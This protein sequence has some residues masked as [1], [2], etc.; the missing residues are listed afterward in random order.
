MVS[1]NGYLHRR[2][3]ADAMFCVGSIVKTLRR[4]RSRNLS[5]KTMRLNNLTKLSYAQGTFIQ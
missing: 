3:Y 5:I 2:V 1:S 4:C